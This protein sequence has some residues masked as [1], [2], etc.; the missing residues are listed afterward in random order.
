MGR[1]CAAETTV[2]GRK[3]LTSLNCSCAVAGTVAAKHS[4]QQHSSKRCQLKPRCMNLPRFWRLPT[5]CCMSV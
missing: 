4:R 1:H 5:S 2:A 3:S